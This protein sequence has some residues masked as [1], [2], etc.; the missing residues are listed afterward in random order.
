MCVCV[1]FA[2]EDNEEILVRKTFPPPRP[3]SRL[4]LIVDQ[5][6]NEGITRRFLPFRNVYSYKH[7]FDFNSF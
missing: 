6:F 3:P 4:T 7:L 5:R 1:T 2:R